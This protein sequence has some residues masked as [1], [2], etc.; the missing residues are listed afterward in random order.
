MNPHVV[1]VIP[2]AIIPGQFLPD[3]SKIDKNVVTIVV[4]SRLV[5]RKGID[6][7]VASAPH[8][9][10]KYPNVRFLI[11]EQWARPEAPSMLTVIAA[12]DGPKRLELLQMRDK[13]D[14]HDQVELLGATRP[15][16]VRSVSGIE[17]VVGA[18]ADLG[19]HLP[20]VRC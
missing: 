12:G 11:G 19:D 18:S 7:L 13:Y 9:C 5:F 8:I 4:I 15:G 16:D 20:S 2:N 10:R 14:L 1:S 17:D 3:T 6:L